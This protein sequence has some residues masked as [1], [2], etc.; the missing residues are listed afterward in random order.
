ML[1]SKEQQDAVVNLLIEDGLVDVALVKKAATEVQKSGQPI[2]AALK[3]R[4][5]KEQ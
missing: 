1:L 2:L 5:L 3:K 4:G